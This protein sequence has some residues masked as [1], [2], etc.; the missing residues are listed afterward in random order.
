[1]TGMTVAEHG[2]RDNGTY[3]VSDE[4]ST[5][6]E[7]LANCGYA[8]AAFIS[9]FVLDSRFGLSQGFEVYDDEMTDEIPSVLD[10][11]QTWQGHEVD[12]FERGADVTTD[13]ALKWLFRRSDDERPFFMW[14]HYFDP[15]KPYMRHENVP[16]KAA[17][18]YDQE[19][20]YV[21]L[22]FGRLLDHL[23]HTEL[24]RDC[25]I[26]VA[27]DHGE[28][29]GEHGLE[30]HGTD[31]Y[32]F[33]MK[34]VLI[35]HFPGRIR[36][37][38]LSMSTGMDVIP[39]TVLQILG[40]ENGVFRSKGLFDDTIGDFSEVGQPKI[41]LE[42]MLP[43]LRD[44]ESRTS[45][46]VD[47]EFKLVHYADDERTLL[48]NI[49]RDPKELKDLSTQFPERTRRMLEDLEKLVP[50]FSSDR[51]KRKDLDDETRSKLEALGYL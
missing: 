41:Y 31:I 36:A 40:L 51:V 38:R 25:L 4:V 24:I 34:T 48:F 18:P 14:V 47:G 42:A 9:S 23:D 49:K 17:R 26:V 10:A 2:V 7:Y 27:S 50:K 43:F 20:A 12:G 13:K 46:I 37:K 16:G 5:L 30:G 35:F 21:D 19:V 29:L 39:S 28:N 45:G 1:M 15:H 6:A 22:H 32:D 33:S 11:T 8:T 44:G 3:R